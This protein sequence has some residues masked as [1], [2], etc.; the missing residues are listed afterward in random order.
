V[1]LSHSG[2]AREAIVAIKP[3]LNPKR[4]PRR[5]RRPQSDTSESDLGEPV[6]GF[7][8]FSDRQLLDDLFD[9]PAGQRIAE[10]GT[11]SHAKLG[12]ESIEMGADGAM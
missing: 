8:D 5:G 12:E 4:R 1:W 2:G 9:A 11:A 6:S 10:G 7:G 3:L